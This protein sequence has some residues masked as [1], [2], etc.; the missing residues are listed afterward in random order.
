MDETL[1]QSVEQDVSAWLGT[2]E[3]G[4]GNNFSF[5]ERYDEEVME[6]RICVFTPKPRLCLYQPADFKHEVL[7]W[8]RFQA[9]AR[10]A[11]IL[12]GTAPPLK[13]QP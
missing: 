4:E 1:L 11:K 13:A 12:K 7:V 5:E 10:N 3:D 2:E 8:V 6:T 9:R